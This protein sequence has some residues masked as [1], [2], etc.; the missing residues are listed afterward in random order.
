MI[1]LMGKL[2]YK[3]NRSSFNPKTILS[4]LF[5]FILLILVIGLSNINQIRKILKSRASESASELKAF[6][7]AE[8]VGAYTKGGRG[9]RVYL[10]TSLANSGAG[11]LRECAEASGPRVCIFRTGGT[12]TLTSNIEIR[13]PEITIAGQTASGDGI[14]LRNAPGNTSEPLKIS[15]GEVIVRYL[16]FRPGF[17]NRAL[18]ISAGSK[19]EHIHDPKT[20]DPYSD[21]ARKLAAEC[22]PK[23]Q[24]VVIDHNSFS[25]AGDELTINWWATYNVTWQWNILSESLGPGWKGGPSLGKWE[26]GGPYS[27]HHNLI[28]NHKFRLPNIAAG[29][30][31][32]D[33]VNN[34]I[35]NFYNKGA[36]VKLG[37]MVNLVNNYIKAGPNTASNATYV[38]NQL[39]VPDP[40]LLGHPLPNAYDPAN[41]SKLSRGYYVSGNFIDGSYGGATKIQGILPA[42]V[43]DDPRTKDYIKDTPY[44]APDM[45]TDTAQDAYDRVLALDGAGAS[46]GLDCNGSWFPRRDT[47]DTRVVKSV[48]DQTRGHNATTNTEVGYI[49]SPSQTAGPGTTADGYPILSEGTPCADADADGMFDEWETDRFGN[50]SRGTTSNSS[51]DYDNDGYTDLEEFLNGTDP[52][53][54]N[55]GGAQLPS[56]TVSKLTSTPIPANTSIPSASATKMPTSIPTKTPIQTKTPTPQITSTQATK[57]LYPVAD[58]FVKQSAPG[59]NYGDSNKLEVDNNPS[60][61]SYLKFN[62][63]SLDKKTIQS[64]KLRLRITNESSDVQ[65]IR[66]AEN[67]GWNENDITYNNRP[68]GTANLKTFNGAKSGQWFIIDIT[69]FIKQKQGKRI[70]LMIDMNGNNGLDFYSRESEAYKPTLEVAYR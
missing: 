47:V 1:L 49:T 14:L 30:G 24:N 42:S 65:R 23:V 26:N 9:G 12:I 7:E 25:W 19:C 31:T 57:Y 36:A 37:A 35:Y 38:D 41:P 16:R 60:T 4:L 45:K 40:D 28:A 63:E 20:G 2:R 69:S 52:T 27:V 18:S 54:N 22:A 8:G 68:L 50:T 29:G 44:P 55:T 61:I 15:A 59:R 48:I 58:T 3:K 17:G 21:D 51:S 33:L 43:P 56:P 34:V 32:S 46:Q 10:I 67:T 62:L 70:T 6:P 66:I 39:D 64:A 53:V 13:D 11:T 5:I